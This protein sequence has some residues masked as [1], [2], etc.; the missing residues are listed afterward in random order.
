MNTLV[1]ITVVTDSEEQARTAV[2][3]AFGSIERMEDL[4]SFWISTSEIAAINREAGISPVSVS[5]ETWEIARQAV[6]IYRTTEGAFDPTIGPVIRLWDFWNRK[7]PDPNE[8]SRSLPLV[9]GSALKVDSGGQTVFLS[10]KGMS[11]DTG[12]IAKGFAADKAV[13][14]LKAEGI[15]SGLVA[16][17]GDI[18]AFGL[19][20]DGEPWRVGIRNPRPVGGEDIIMAT[21]PLL[22]EAISTSGD[23]ERFFEVD[24]KRYHHLLNPKTGLPADGY[25]SVTIVAPEAVLTDGF[26]TGIFVLGPERG[27]AVMAREGLEGVLVTASGEIIVTDGLKERIVWKHTPELSSG[28]RQ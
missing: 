13:A 8:L 17:A 11:F 4:L 15:R 3:K 28:Q 1:T 21:L 24:G 9:D 26:T 10:K 2:E 5:P 22:D 27:A 20:P 14:A 25:V 19:R 6:Y 16:I 18:R 23:Y 7:R 12:G